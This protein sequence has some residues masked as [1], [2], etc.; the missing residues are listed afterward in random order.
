MEQ[1]QHL[2][3]AFDEWLGKTNPVAQQAIRPHLSQA[4]SLDFND[5]SNKKFSVLPFEL[6]QLFQGALEAIPRVKH[7]PHCARRH[8]SK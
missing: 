1:Q 2:V 6:P 5:A 4:F 3:F 7:R 8:V